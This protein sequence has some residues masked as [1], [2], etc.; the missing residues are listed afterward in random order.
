MP[1]P[2]NRN[3][4]SYRNGT[5]VS[6]A[7]VLIVSVSGFFMGLRQ[8]ATTAASRDL[9]QIVAHL[10]AE[11]GAAPE[12]QGYATMREL[13]KA[14]YGWSNSIALLPSLQRDLTATNAASPE[15]RTSAVKV[16]RARRAYEGAPPVIPHA[17]DQTSAA[18][19]LACHGE[20]KIIKDKIASR[21]SH[22]HY[23]NCTQCHVPAEGGLPGPV[24]VLAGLELNDAATAGNGFRGLASFGGGTKAFR[25]APP[26]IPHPTLMRTDCISCHGSGGVAGLRTSHQSR[27]SCTQ[28]HVPSAEYDQRN[29]LS[30]F[31]PKARP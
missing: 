13:P 21:I 25:G 20:G 19:C 14:N 31:E 24:E 12:V 5:R 15:D 6:L 26:T 23:S 18:A 7:I 27:Q 29:F 1:E 22:A 3:P 8:T 9:S 16:R 11:T 2:N 28:C 10:P 4:D 30:L 17:I